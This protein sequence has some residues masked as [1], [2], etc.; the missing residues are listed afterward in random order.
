MLDELWE[1]A[2]YFDWI[3][4]TLAMAND[5]ARGPSHTFLIPVQCGWTG[6]EIS[7]GLRN[8]GIET[9]GHMIV[10]D[11]FMITVRDDD[12]GAAHQLMAKAGLPVGS[13]PGSGPGPGNSYSARRNSSRS[14]RQSK[15]QRKG[16]ILDDLADLLFG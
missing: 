12:A 7:N 1:A 4:P 11:H 5:V 8:H 15:S 10:N 6:R 9:W 14:S 2:T 3:S 13:S 16:S